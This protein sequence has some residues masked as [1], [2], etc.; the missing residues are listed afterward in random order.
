MDF[1]KCPYNPSHTFDEE[2]YTFHIL[3]CKDGLK[4]S[5]LF[6]KCRFNPLHIFRREDVEV[7][8]TICPDKFQSNRNHHNLLRIAELY[9][10]PINHEVII[11]DEEIVKK[12]EEKS[13]VKEERSFPI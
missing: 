3:R 7:H 2:K 4:F 11:K 9:N 13:I 10:N 5:H 1:T 12:S 6:E 8:E